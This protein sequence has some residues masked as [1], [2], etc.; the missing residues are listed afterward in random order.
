MKSNFTAKDFELFKSVAKLPE[1][2][3]YR[4]LTSVLKECYETENV[5]VGP[6]NQ[7]VMAKGDIPVMLVAH[8][9]T[10][11]KIPHVTF[12]GIEIKM[13]SLRMGLVLG[14][15]IELEFL[16]FFIF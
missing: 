12:S 5:I 14:P 8:L 7:Y 2:S 3:L 9:D 10:V 13:L 4:G 11:F 1:S 6:E 16:G 15:T